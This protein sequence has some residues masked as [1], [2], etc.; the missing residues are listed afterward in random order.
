MLLSDLDYSYPP[1]LV[2]TEPARPTRVGFFR[3][4]QAAEELDLGALIARFRPGDLLV[5]NNSRVIPARVFSLAGDEILFLRAL[6]PLHW[7]VLFPARRYKLHDPIELPDDVQ[8]HV[9]QKG[10]PQQLILSRPLDCAYFETHG[11]MALPPYIQERRNERHSRAHDREWYQSVWACVNG[12]VAA[13]TASLHFQPSH[14]EQLSARGV[15]VV[16]VT[17]HV[18]AGTFLPIRQERL[19]QHEMH[20]ER[21]FV[22]ALTRER[23]DQT[24]RHGGH[25]WAL[26]TTVTRSL[27]S[28]AQG[29]LTPTAE[30]YTAETKLFIRPPFK[31]QLVDVLMTNF[32]QPR[33][34][35]LSLVAAFAGLESVKAGYTWAIERQFKLFSYGD[36]SV[37]MPRSV[38]SR[39]NRPKVRPAPPA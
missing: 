19:D 30:G 15:G 37:W 9:Q 16:P 11:E 23:I 18:G 10:L 4:G 26:G 2:A 14:L 22:P 6:S 1:D 24:K 20:A 13:P 35:L 36:L 5:I 39:C 33:S 8:A 21:V 27:E 17:L 34:T 3:S 32:H 12:S 31:F 25:I 7:E 38:N 28:L 29:L